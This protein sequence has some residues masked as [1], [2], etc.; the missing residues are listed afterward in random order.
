MNQHLSSF[1]TFTVP[2]IREITSLIDVG[3]SPVVKDQTD[4]G[5]NWYLLHLATV[6]KE[7]TPNTR[8][9][10]REKPSLS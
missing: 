5:L 10:I 8:R 1:A 6:L 3:T 7:K 9:E 2:F 4:R